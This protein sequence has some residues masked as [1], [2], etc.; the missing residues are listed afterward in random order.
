MHSSTVTGA[1]AIL[2]ALAPSAWAVGSAKVINNCD[3]DVYYASVSQGVSAEP[4]LIQGSYSE[5]YSLHNNGVSIKLALEPNLGGEVSQFEFTW[6]DGNTAYDLSNIDGYPFAEWG[7]TIEPSVSADSDYP[8]CVPVDCPAGE[9]PCDAAYNLPDDVRT[10]R[11]NRWGGGN[12]AFAHV[13][14]RIHPRS[15]KVDA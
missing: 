13:H 12:R 7:I 8:T 3:F 2:L 6:Y 9:V 14:N 10:L 4:A 5:K 1:A 11:F 15:F